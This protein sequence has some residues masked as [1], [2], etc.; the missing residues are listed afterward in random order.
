MGGKIQK[1]EIEPV[2]ILKQRKLSIAMTTLESV[3]LVQRLE[4]V[5]GNWRKREE[6][7]SSTI[8]ANLGLWV[9][10]SRRWMLRDVK[11]ILERLFW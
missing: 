4:W 6:P 1:S 9:L 3:G 7:V 8:I 11:D 10:N 2:M 5:G